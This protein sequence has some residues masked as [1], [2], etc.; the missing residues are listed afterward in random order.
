MSPYSRYRPLPGSDG[1]AVL[2]TPP[3]CRPSSTSA[4]R[5]LRWIS[6]LSPQPVNKQGL[7]KSFALL[8]AVET[9]MGESQYVCYG[10][11]L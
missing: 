6:K 2:Q 5:F 1:L 8:V 7:G 11:F 9:S 4:C 10:D 3:G